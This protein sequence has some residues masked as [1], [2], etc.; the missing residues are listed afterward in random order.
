MGSELGDG[1]ANLDIGIDPGSVGAGGQGRIPVVELAA[2]SQIPGQGNGPR[3]LNFVEITAV[4]GHFGCGAFDVKTGTIRIGDAT[5][6]IV[7]ELTAVD[8]RSTLINDQR[9][10]SGDRLHVPVGPECAA[11]D[12]QLGIVVVL[13]DRTAV[14]GVA[15]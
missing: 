14:I 10:L 3:E 12:G 11:V 5:Y 4:Q 1:A 6:A 7:A 2:A 13:I 9:R 15:F 8:H